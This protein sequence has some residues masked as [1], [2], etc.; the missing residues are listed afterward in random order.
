MIQMLLLLVIGLALSALFSGSETGFLSGH[1]DSTV[2]RS[3]DGQSVVAS[4]DVAGQS[5]DDV[6]GDNACW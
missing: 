4:I 1:A 6:C 5:T 2:D 3:T